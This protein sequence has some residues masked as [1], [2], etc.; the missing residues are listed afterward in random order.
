MGVP[1]KIADARQLVSMMSV[2]R[3]GEGGCH[4]TMDSPIRHQLHPPAGMT[5][6]MLS[7]SF[8]SA[9]MPWPTSAT[10]GCFPCCHWEAQ[11][12]ASRSF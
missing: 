4:R 5:T 10:R 9:A 7:S 6:P 12:A 2:P 1:P 11:V 8:K 3:R